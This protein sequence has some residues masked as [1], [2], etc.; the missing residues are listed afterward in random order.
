MIEGFIPK[1][2]VLDMILDLRNSFEK[3]FSGYAGDVVVS[4]FVVTLDDKLRELK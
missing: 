2:E 4:D 1:Q 3:A